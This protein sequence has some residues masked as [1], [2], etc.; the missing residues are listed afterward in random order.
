[1][2]GHPALKLQR[3]PRLR[4][5]GP[6]FP[7]DDVRALRRSELVKEPWTSRDCCSPFVP[8]FAGAYDMDASQVKTLSGRQEIVRTISNEVINADSATKYR[9][10]VAMGLNPCAFVDSDP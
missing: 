1:M 3:L 9:E 4:D 5:H 8:R 7:I 6:P 2:R 10:G